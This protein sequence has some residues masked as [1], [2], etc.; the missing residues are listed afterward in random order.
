MNFKVT[1]LVVKT[2]VGEPIDLASMGCILHRLKYNPER[3]R[4]ASLKLDAG[5][6]A[7]IWPNGTLVFA[8][9]KSMQQVE[10]CGKKL[11][12]ILKNFGYVVGELNYTI[13]SVASVCNIAEQI[14]LDDL[15]KSL[16]H[17]VPMIYLPEVFS[18]LTLKYK[19]GTLCVFHT[20]KIVILGTKS[21]GDSLDIA[22]DIANIGLYNLFNNKM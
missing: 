14:V 17:V 18:K 2:T 7:T 20:G 8:G 19:T 16:Q 11:K 12:K 1:N 10:E 13:C 5:G 15:Y 21:V 4:G 6:V 22:N 3:F 9:C